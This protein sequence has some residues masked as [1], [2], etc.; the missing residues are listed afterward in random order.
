MTDLFIAGHG[1]NKRTGRFDSGATGFIHKGEHRYMVEDLFPAMRK[2]LPDGVKPIFHTEYDVY[3]Q[4]DIVSLAKKYG[5]NTRVTEFHF[6]G[7]LNRSAKGGHVIIHKSYKPDDLDIK[8]RN[9]ISDTVGINSAYKHRGYTGVS[10]RS[11]LGNTN[12]CA[13]GGVNYRLL[14]LG[15]GSNKTDSDYMIKNVDTIAKELVK[16]FYG[17]IKIAS[18]STQLYK[19]QVG[20]FTHIDNAKRLRNELIGKGYMDTFVNTKGKLNRV[21][22][23]AF[24]KLDNAKKLRNELIKKGY[25]DTFIVS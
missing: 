24:S 2:Y 20:A 5:K 3:K 23:G 4:G 19:V 22:V 6:D 15:F 12:R 9:A 13:K 17:K 25:K 18:N 21:Q 10:G 11:D 16:A 1:K 14:E 7:A 8:L